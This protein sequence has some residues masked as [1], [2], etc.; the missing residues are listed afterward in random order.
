MNLIYTIIEIN[1]ILNFINCNNNLNNCDYKCKFSKY[2]KNVNFQKYNK[3]I[4]QR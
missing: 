1:K 3:S 4:K 2:I